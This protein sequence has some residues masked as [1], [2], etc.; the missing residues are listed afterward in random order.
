VFG[1]FKD[2]KIDGISMSVMCRNFSYFSEICVWL[3]IKSREILKII[4]NGLNVAL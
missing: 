2:G 3:N 4:L 1:K